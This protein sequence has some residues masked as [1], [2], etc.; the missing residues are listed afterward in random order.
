MYFFTNSDGSVIDAKPMSDPI[1]SQAVVRNF[2][3]KSIAELFSFHYR[4]VEMHLQRMAPDILTDQAFKDVVAELDRMGL[5]RQMKE[6]REV[7][8]TTIPDTPVLTASGTQNGI[9][10]WEYASRINILLE[11]AERSSG[12][13]NRGRIRQLSGQLRAQLIRV[14]PEVH[15]RR[16]LI[17]RLQIFEEGAR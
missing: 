8:V 12:S 3:S 17:N 16:V 5:V 4:N 9:H 11:G 10:A 13:G 14:P 15:P 6:R 7:A 2:L 1:H